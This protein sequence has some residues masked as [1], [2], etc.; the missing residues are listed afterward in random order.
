MR[1]RPGRGEP[2][3]AGASVPLPLYAGA[4]G[5]A[6]GK[7]GVRR[8]PQRGGC[9]RA[10]GGDRS[11]GGEIPVPWGAVPVAGLLRG[12]HPDVSGPGP[13]LRGD[14]PGRG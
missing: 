2:G 4:A 7:A 8:G 13:A 3:A 14:G 9:P 6:C 1:S 5:A 11:R 12:D 10:A